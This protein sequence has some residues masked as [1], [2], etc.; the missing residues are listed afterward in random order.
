[1]AVLGNFEF[2]ISSLYYSTLALLP[3]C[4]IP[5]LQ[6]L[7]LTVRSLLP[8]IG[9]ATQPC[10]FCLQRHD[11][12][13]SRHS[14]TTLASTA[15]LLVFL[16]QRY[17]CSCVYCQQ[18]EQRSQSRPMKCME[19]MTSSGSLSSFL[20]RAYTVSRIASKSGAIFLPVAKPWCPCAPNAKHMAPSCTLFHHR[21]YICWKRMRTIPAWTSQWFHEAWISNVMFSGSFR[22]TPVRL[23]LKIIF[24]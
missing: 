11:K 17:L 14:K 24:E 12:H 16:I 4:L 21:W 10:P 8:K 3:S 13:L 22:F 23:V 6:A 9:H 15:I 19:L 2:N 18:L 1:M 20:A 5:C 7:P